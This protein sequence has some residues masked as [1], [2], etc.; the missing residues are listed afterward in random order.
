MS[1]KSYEGLVARTNDEIYKI[2]PI[3]E[4]EVPRKG[5]I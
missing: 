4:V 5:L 2:K 1:P 3:S